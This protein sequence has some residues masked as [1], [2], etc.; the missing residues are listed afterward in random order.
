M[1]QVHK[2]T[3]K[4]YV[5]LAFFQDAILHFYADKYQ[6]DYID[7]LRSVI[8]HYARADNRF[9]PA[10]FQ[11]FVANRFPRVLENSGIEV[12]KEMAQE[13]DRQVETFLGARYDPNVSTTSIVRESIPARAR[14]KRTKR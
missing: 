3:R 7:I 11:E 1:P 12:S 6:R 10:E 13:I 14:K 5:S 4:I 8:T 9:D 2:S